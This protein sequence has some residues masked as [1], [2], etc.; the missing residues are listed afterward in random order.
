[1][2]IIGIDLG[3][4]NSLVS[5]LQDGEPIVLTNELGDDLTPS[6]VALASDG[7]PLVGRSAKDR[8]ITDSSA[9]KAFF[10]RDMGTDVMYSIGDQEWSAI[11]CSARILRELK[12]IAEERLGTVIDKT[13]IT[14]PA[15]F[16]DTQRKATIDAAKLVGLS[17]ER[18]INEPTAAALAY[19]YQNPDEEKNLLVFDI[20][21]GTFDVTVLE[22]FDGIV[23][24]KASN[25]ISQLGG[26]D[27][28]D[29]LL[30]A[31]LDR[32]D[33]SIPDGE[34]NRWRQRVE[35]AKCELSKQAA[36]RVVLA[37]QELIVD[38]AFFLEVTGGLTARLDK[39]VSQCLRDANLSP[40]NIDDVLMVGGASRM[41]EIN[42]YVADRLAKIPNQK[43]D[44]DRVVA[45]GAAIQAGLCSRDS[46]VEDLVLTDVCPHTLGIEMTKEVTVGQYK[47]GYYQ[48]IIDRNTTV[49]VSRSHPF[50]TLHPNQDEVQVK[51]Y[52]G[53]HRF[54]DG[55][56]LLGVITVQ[57][58]RKSKKNSD[59]GG[60]DVRFTYDMNGI[61]E[62]DVIKH[63]N[64]D[65][66]TKVFEQR[67][68]SMTQVQIDEALA[69]LRPLKI[70][71]RDRLPNRVRLEQADRLFSELS[72]ALRDNLV[73]LVDDFDRA[74]ASQEEANI[75]E[76]VAF[77]DNFMGQFL[78]NEPSYRPSRPDGP[79]AG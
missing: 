15:Y 66:V 1:M 14:V 12:R 76:S 26:E 24:V 8:L 65:R 36:S 2:T 41:V 42:R 73:M 48:P 63:H 18:I 45:Y 40:N 50:H 20:G 3:T 62:V 4:T 33:L 61:L 70:H 21:G 30:D 37:D 59:A 44:P 43:V 27:Y 39:I 31:L 75:K 28:T 51:V 79:E 54:I 17:V 13:V 55:N 78:D 53:E 19:G 6:V 52:Q 10:K 77:L 67:P 5:Y 35:M 32:Y 23:E 74:L 71:P 22:I 46:A 56:K 11:E 60:F 7:K 64:G 38:R 29:A 16:H 25:G 69:R 58:L 72:G 68:G 47:E 57:G 49:P 34:Y 9:G